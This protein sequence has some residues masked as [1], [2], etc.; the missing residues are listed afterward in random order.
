MLALGAGLILMM[1]FKPEGILGGPRRR[2][3][4][5]PDDEKTLM[6]EMETIKR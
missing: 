6:Q 1:V 3:E 2:A 5:R 4:L